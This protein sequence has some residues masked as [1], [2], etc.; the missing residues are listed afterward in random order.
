[1]ALPVFAVI[2]HH[3]FIAYL[4]KILD[5]GSRLLAFAGLPVVTERET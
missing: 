3:V 2:G 1:V 4:I 5:H